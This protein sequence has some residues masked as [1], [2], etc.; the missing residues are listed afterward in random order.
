MYLYYS[1]MKMRGSKSFLGAILLYNGRKCRY[2][3]NVVK[4]AFFHEISVAKVGGQNFLNI[5]T[6]HPKDILTRY[7]SR[8]YGVT[9][10]YFF[11]IFSSFLKCRENF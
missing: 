3:I 1:R 2:L 4:V 5:G 7:Q 11:L 8:E 9:N 6:E 10:L